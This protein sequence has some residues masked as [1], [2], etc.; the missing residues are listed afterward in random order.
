MCKIDLISFLNYY[1][2]QNNK[3]AYYIQMRMKE[4]KE[5]YSLVTKLIHARLQV[6]LCLR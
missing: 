5:K 4:L 3:I 2:W 6:L 1:G